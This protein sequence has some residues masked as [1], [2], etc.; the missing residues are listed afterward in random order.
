MRVIGDPER[1]FMKIK[2]N[3]RGP[4]GYE[5][6]DPSDPDFPVGKLTEIPNFLPPPGE[7]GVNFPAAEP[8]AAPPNRI[9]ANEKPVGSVTPRSFAQG[10]QRHTFFICPSTS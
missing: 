9:S 7:P 4:D 1:F 10:S 2:R 8:I 3:K 5:D 6:D